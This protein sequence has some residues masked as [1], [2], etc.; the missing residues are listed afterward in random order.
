MARVLAS[1]RV[2]VARLADGRCGQRW[3]AVF[4]QHGNLGCA[5]GQ[6]LAAAVDGGRPASAA[7]KTG[8]SNL[9]PRRTRRGAFR[10]GR[11]RVGMERED[12]RWQTE[13]GSEAQPTDRRQRADCDRVAGGAGWLPGAGGSLAGDAGGL[14][15]AQRL[16]ACGERRCRADRGGRRQGFDPTRTRPIPRRSGRETAAG[17]CLSVSS[18]GLQLWDSGGSGHA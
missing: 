11:N 9:H 17:V 13:I 5:G 6:R 7:R 14:A 15:A 3:R 1:Q 2:G 18:G 8:R 12:G 16:A 4:L 10:G